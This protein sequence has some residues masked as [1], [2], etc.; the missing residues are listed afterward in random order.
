[1]LGQETRTSRPGGSALQVGWKQVLA[2]REGSGR[3]LTLPLLLLQLL[4]EELALKY[5]S[6]SFEL[7]IIA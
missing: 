5:N 4:L 7:S 2:L 6:T 1:M 3:P